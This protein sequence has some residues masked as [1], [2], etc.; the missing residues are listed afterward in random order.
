VNLLTKELKK[1]FEKFLIGSQDGKGAEALVVVKYFG[2]G[3]YSFFATE[4]E[5]D[6]DDF[7]LY[8]Y[9]ISPLGP[10]CDEWGYS[11]LQ[12]LQAARFAFG[13]GVERDLWVKPAKQTVKE[14]AGSQRGEIGS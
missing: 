2:G 8:G 12:E 1:T 10:D 5:P 11:S 14:L 13:L 3:R 7:R 6:G 4:G 9:C